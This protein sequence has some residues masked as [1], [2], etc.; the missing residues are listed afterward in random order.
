M[1]AYLKNAEEVMEEQSS[2]KNVEA[3]LVSLSCTTVVIYISFLSDTFGFEHISAMEY[4]AAL[5]VAVLVIPIV[6][7]TK[8][9]QRK[10]KK[11]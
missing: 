6:E 9:I 10:R 7:V 4:A 5:L 11:N 1:K 3:M 2:S 8:V